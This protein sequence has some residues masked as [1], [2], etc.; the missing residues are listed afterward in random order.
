MISINLSLTI[1]LG[2]KGYFL[3]YKK[4]GIKWKN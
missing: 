1:V 4:Q 3:P 2:Y